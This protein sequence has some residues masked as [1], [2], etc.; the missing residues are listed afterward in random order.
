MKKTLI[1]ILFFC[2]CNSLPLW[3]DGHKKGPSKIESVPSSASFL[4]RPASNS[5]TKQTSREAVARLTDAINH[6]YDV[7]NF[8]KPYPLVRIVSPGKGGLSGLDAMATAVVT[9]DGK[10]ILY[11]NREWL[12]SSR[13]ITETVVHE[14]AHFA[15]WRRY[16]YSVDA[17]GWQFTNLCRSVTK[18][19]H[20]TAY[21]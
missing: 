19:K 5:S 7:L 20:C 21:N 4:L 17:H 1:L 18:P 2:G 10:E 16:G 8:E 13:D 14:Y 9:E 11:F 6:A 3:A 15:T 12:E